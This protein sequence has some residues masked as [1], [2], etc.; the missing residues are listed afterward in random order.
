MA[1]LTELKKTLPTYYTLSNQKLILMAHVRDETVYF[2]D[3]L[4]PTTTIILLSQPKCY[5]LKKIFLDFMN[6]LGTT[7]IDLQEP[8]TFDV[9]YIIG[10]RSLR[11]IR[12]FLRDYRFDK[13][14]THPRYSKEN[15]SQNRALY[16]LIRDY[17]A[18]I[19]KDNHYTYNKI[20]TYG[21]PK[22]PCGIKKGI[23]ELYCRVLNRDNK[24]DEKM[25][26][27]FSS[28]TSNISGTR[29]I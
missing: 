3:E 8:E 12:S 10:N 7:V 1:S 15:D 24:L 5:A 16:D 13:I 26:K 11:I 23:L 18:A 29:R 14:I 4:G 22:L 6:D 28:I 17:V 21:T 2:Y 27:N 19:G 9:D 20:G 25:Y